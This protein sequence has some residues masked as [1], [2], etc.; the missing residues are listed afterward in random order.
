MPN[1]FNNYTTIRF[2][3]P[4]KTKVDL[5]VYNSTGRLV[6]TLVNS[7]MNPGYYTMSWNGKDDIS[8]TQGNGIYFIRLKTKDYDMTKKMVLVK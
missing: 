2:Q 4:T 1:P 8:R 5:K 6:N 3:I 7:E